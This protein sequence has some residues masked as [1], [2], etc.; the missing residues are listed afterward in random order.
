[1]T[2]V[3]LLFVYGTLKRGHCRAHLLDGQRF[4]GDVRTRPFYRLYDCGDYPALARDADGVSI[5]GELYQVNSQCLQTLDD[6]EGVSQQLY[7]RGEVEI[8]P[9][10]GSRTVIS[11]FYLQSVAGLR[12]CGSTWP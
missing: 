7:E 3:S 10:L 12:D 11:Y 4:L 8:V 6:V 1:M 5:N 2:D 9:P